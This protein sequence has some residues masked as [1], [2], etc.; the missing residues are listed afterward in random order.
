VQVQGKWKMVSYQATIILP[1]PPPPLV[2]PGT[3]ATPKK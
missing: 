3:Q 1:P 2:T